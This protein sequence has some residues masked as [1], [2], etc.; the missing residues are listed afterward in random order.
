MDKF[1]KILSYF[2]NNEWL[3]TNN[4]IQQL[5]Q[6]LD[7]KDKKLFYFSMADM[8]WLEYFRNY[9]L[10]LRVYL[11]KDDESTLPAARRKQIR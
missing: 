1:T 9:T 3:F 11:Y 10:G 7:V 5:W 8:D 6:T 2:A 4:N